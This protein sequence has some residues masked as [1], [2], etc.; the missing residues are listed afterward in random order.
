MD[1]PGLS[2]SRLVVHWSFIPSLEMPWN[3]AA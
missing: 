3:K 2:P 1:R